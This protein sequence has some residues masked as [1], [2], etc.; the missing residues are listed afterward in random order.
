MSK[1][2]TKQVVQAVS[3]LFQLHG[4]KAEVEG[5]QYSGKNG[6]WGSDSTIE[7]SFNKEVATGMA[8]FSQKY[9]FPYARI[10]PNRQVVLVGVRYEHHSGGSNGWT[11]DFVIVPEEMFGEVPRVDLIRNRDYQ[12]VAQ[13]IRSNQKEGE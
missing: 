5:V 6:D 10:W 11:D 9:V 12:K 2:L 3:E 1:D 13:V 8:S 7:F 4:F